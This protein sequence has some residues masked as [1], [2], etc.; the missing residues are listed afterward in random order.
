MFLTRNG[1]C[2]VPRGHVILD[3]K[4]DLRDC[5]PRSA[6][7]RWA[8]VGAGTW[9]RHRPDLQNLSVYEEEKAVM[10]LAEDGA[11]VL[12]SNRGL[13]LGTP[14]PWRGRETELWAECFLGR[15]L[16]VV[17]ARGAWLP[18]LSWHRPRYP[19]SP[20][21]YRNV[22]QHFGGPLGGRGT[23]RSLWWFVPGAGSTSRGLG[24][25]SP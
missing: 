7:T 22:R 1:H 5:V 19:G 20:S 14:P 2:K 18:P 24:S 10:P 8:A 12:I 25:R 23:A 16:S 3:S 11:I 17:S 6:V 13:G 4:S 21:A 15:P 9:H